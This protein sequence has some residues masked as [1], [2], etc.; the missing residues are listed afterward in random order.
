MAPKAGTY[1]KPTYYAIVN[2]SDYQHYKFRNPPWIKFHTALLDDPKMRAL[3][4]PTQLLWDRLLLCAGRFANVL[5]TESEVIANL[6][7]VPTRNVREGIPLL[8]K[9]RWIKETRTPRRASKAASK[10]ASPKQAP[11]QE[12]EQEKELL[13]AEQERSK[14]NPREPI[15]PALLDQ[16]L[17]QQ[18]RDIEARLGSLSAPGSLDSIIALIPPEQRDP[19]TPVTIGRAIAPLTAHQRE[20]L[21]DEIANAGPDVR[22]RAKYA[23]QIAKRMAVPHIHGKGAA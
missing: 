11:K 12:Q 5:P 6:T 21:H 3:P 4:I 2:W 13:L 10:G 7:G 23:V 9:G 17:E 19:Q 14:E 15:D 8:L 18:A 20:L 16:E 22:H 1:G